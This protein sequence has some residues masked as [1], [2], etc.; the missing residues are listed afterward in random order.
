VR[1]AKKVLMIGLDAISPQL[2]SRFI[3]EGILPNLEKVAKRGIFTKVIPAMPA[4]T[5]TNW[6]TLATGAWPGTHGIH[7][8]GTHRWGEPLSERHTDEA[9]SSNICK[10]EYFWETT[11][12][13]DRKS[14]LVNYPGYPPTTDKAIHVGWLW[15]P[16]DYYFEISRS[17]GYRNYNTD[18]Q[19]GELIFRSAEQWQNLPASK[20]P[21]LEA[22]LGVEPKEMGSGV[23]YN[24]LLV[25]TERT[26]YNVM[27]ICK[28]KNAAY[29]VATLK[30]G[31][32]SPWQRERFIIRDKQK[33][34]TVRFKLIG[35]SADA[36][37][38]WI[39]RSQ[40][41]PV[42]GFIFPQEWENKLLEVCGPY[43]NEHAWNTYY[44]GGADEATCREE[45]AYQSQ[46]VGKAVDYL[47]RSAG[48]TVYFQH[49]HLPDHV[50]HH[51][52]H[53]IDPEAEG[54]D[55]V[56]S[57]RG[58]RE[59]RLAYKIAD[60]MVG[61]VLKASDEDTLIVVASDHGMPVNKKAVSLINLFRKKGW[62]KLEKT[63]NGEV[64][65]DWSKTKVY[66]TRQNLYVYINLKG[67]DPHGIVEP[68]SK[69]EKLREKIID[70]LLDLRDPADGERVISFALKREEAWFTGFWGEGV[71]DVI[72]CYAPGCRWT[73]EEVVLLGE[74]RVIWPNV[75][76]N[77]G[78]QPSTAETSIASNYATLIM[79]GPGVRQNYI[80]S[81]ESLA[82]VNMVDIAPTIAYLM[83][84]PAPAQNE[85]KLIHDIIE[86]HQGFKPRKP[87]PLHFPVKRKRK[88]PRKIALAGDVTDEEL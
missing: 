55:P 85:G 16:N 41:Y 74:E 12:R 79:A 27:L 7:T 11:A 57:K 32:W 51:F 50:G 58:W 45:F 30:E 4:F 17:Y 68:G 1:K 31:E 87:Q 5:T 37:K 22:E 43:I 48:V 67:R 40:V 23:K 62:A 24:L 10:A 63:E 44:V 70:A 66:I 78:C 26:G 8:W 65:Y 84:L 6:T 73:A 75:G 76:S 29:P 21:V 42:C 9:F 34:G 83:G 81:D 46:W 60:Q 61:E 59:I 64:T 88:G 14:L 13:C 38:V 2:T 39:Y 20:Q 19:V 56:K 53:Y 54:Y 86:D 80:R 3:N 15:Q 52:M 33:T 77:H 35:L 82:P 69:Y 72:F 36:S 49:F 28:G 18:G 71:G 25:D 47:M